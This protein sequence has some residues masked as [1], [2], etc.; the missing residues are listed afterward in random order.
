MNDG[1]SGLCQAMADYLSGCGAAAVTAWSM[2]PR[3]E[4]GPVAVVTLRGC[5]AESAG[6][7]DYLGERYNEQTGLW[8]ELFGKKARI[9]L[10]L[11]L[12]A[13]EKEDGY[14]LRQAF[15]RL[16]EALILGGPEGVRVEEFSCGETAY[17]GE[18]RRLRK[19]VEAVC[20][21]YLGAAA[22]S[23]GEF[24]DFELRGVVKP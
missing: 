23:G 24:N 5:R 11:D 22:G 17:D 7:Q 10:G 16:A 3:Q 9:T 13:R 21:V 8:E 18:S 12:Y 14:S 2:T 6:F 4:N 20:S 1:M 15:D 19:P